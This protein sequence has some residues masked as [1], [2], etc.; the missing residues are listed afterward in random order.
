MWPVHGVVRWRCVDLRA[1]IKRRFEVEISERH[2]GRL[3]KRLR[4]TRL[5]VRP[6]HPR[7]DEAAQQAFNKTSPRP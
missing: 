4:F 1:E 7:A 6:R 3:L 5:S 2:V